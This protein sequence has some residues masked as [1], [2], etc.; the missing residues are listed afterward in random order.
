[1]SRI[2]D[3]SSTYNVNKTV[4]I[5]NG[6]HKRTSN[7]WVPLC[8]ASNYSDD[9]SFPAPFVTVKEDKKGYLGASVEISSVQ[10]LLRK[11]ITTTFLNV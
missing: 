2:G 11:Y 6:D 5:G 7:M 4:Q 9:R 8:E 3:T 10:D 1:M